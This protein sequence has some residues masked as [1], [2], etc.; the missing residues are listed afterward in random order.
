MGGLRPY[1]FQ[2][3]PPGF[4]H[5]VHRSFWIPSRVFCIKHGWITHCKTSYFPASQLSDCFWNLDR[6]RMVVLN[7]IYRPLG[8]RIWHVP[9]RISSPDLPSFS[10]ET[11]QDIQVL[12]QL[13][14]K[15]ALWLLSPEIQPETSPTFRVWKEKKGKQRRNSSVINL[16]CGVIKETPSSDSGLRW[17]PRSILLVCSTSMAS[18]TV[19]IWFSSRIFD[20]QTVP[21]KPNLPLSR[22][23]SK[24]PDFLTLSDLSPHVGTLQT[25]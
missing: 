23:E 21:Q 20:I 19:L 14:E 22:A 7:R 12:T 4:I 25:L 10:R 15:S 3:P 11:L 6:M 2:K 17:R 24:C 5:H 18:C 8:P 13:S 1:T 16:C 9:Q